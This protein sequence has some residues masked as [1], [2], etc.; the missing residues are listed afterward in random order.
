MRILTLVESDVRTVT[1][2]N[3]RSVLLLTDKARINQLQPSD[4]ELVSYYGEPEQ[5]RIVSINEVL[6]MRAGELELPDGWRKE[7]MQEILDAACCS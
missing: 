5:W 2:R 7:E 3:L 4:M 1:G 6:Q